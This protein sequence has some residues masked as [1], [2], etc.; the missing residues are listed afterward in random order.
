M[1]TMIRLHYCFR[2]QVQGVGFRYKMYYL[3]QKYGVTGWVRN[4]WDGTVTLEI[5]GREPLIQKLLVG[6]NS[7]QFIKIEWMDTEEIP[8][9]QESSF[10]VR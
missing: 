2:G 4:E 6:L 10:K 7:S 3:A 9:E 8:L 5:Q 1:K